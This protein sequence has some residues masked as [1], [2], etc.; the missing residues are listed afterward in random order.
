MELSCWL[1]PTDIRCALVKKFKKIELTTNK[2]ETVASG[3]FLYQFLKIQ[4]CLILV[5]V[6]FVR[7]MDILGPLSLPGTK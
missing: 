7:S 6:C 1:L 5:E 4:S 2:T 3:V